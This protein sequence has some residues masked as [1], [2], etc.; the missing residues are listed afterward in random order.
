MQPVQ[1]QKLRGVCRSSKLIM[2]N[3][4]AWTQEACRWANKLNNLHESTKALTQNLTT[5]PGLLCSIEFI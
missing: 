2:R 3:T 1:I 4:C 5:D